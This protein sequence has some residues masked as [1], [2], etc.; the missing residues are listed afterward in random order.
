[1]QKIFYYS[2][3]LL[4]FSCGST[5]QTNEIEDTT[6]NWIKNHPVS[7]DYYTG[8]GIVSKSKNPENYIQI[9]HIYYK[10]NAPV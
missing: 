6:P 4:L 3:L 2:L 5:K 1:M 8:I 7:E 10:R 9:A